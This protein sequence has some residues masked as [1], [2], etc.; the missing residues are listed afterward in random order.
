MRTAIILAAV[1]LASGSAWA[2]EQD[3]QP[4]LLTH[5]VPDEAL[6]KERGGESL[7]I[8]LMDLQARL[9]DNVARDNVTGSNIVADGAFN[10]A[11]GLA[12]VIQNTGNNVVIQNAT[13]L[14]LEM[15]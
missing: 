1:V 2:N 8:N 4:D 9:T 10:N 11:S 7:R 15:K 5:A 12:T 3:R 13:I 6:E 14:N